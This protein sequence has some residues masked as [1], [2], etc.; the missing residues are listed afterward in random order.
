[1]VDWRG[2]GTEAWGAPSSAPSPSASAPEPP[3]P[4]DDAAPAPDG[5]PDQSASATPPSPEE[6][7][8]AKDAP[9]PSE[10]GPK[11]AGSA[12]AEALVT[13]DEAQFLRER[14]EQL[15]RSVDR[16]E[17]LVGR[18]QELHLA[19]QRSHDETR[20]QLQEAQARVIGLLEAPREAPPE[21]PTATRSG[22]PAA[23]S[24]PQPPASSAAAIV[25]RDLRLGLMRFSR[26]LRG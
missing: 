11:Q 22:A 12:V 26:W 8:E 7:G 18:A 24:R 23:R 10:E 19:E 13:G 21:P 5:D 4:E 3:P 15:E 6:V 20:H 9:S 14:I 2:F 1:M 16:L 17:Q 25:T